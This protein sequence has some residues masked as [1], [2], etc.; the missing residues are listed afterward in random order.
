[1]GLIQR[2]FFFLMGSLLKIVR[3]KV[4]KDFCEGNVLENQNI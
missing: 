4:D 2:P 3:C 1:M